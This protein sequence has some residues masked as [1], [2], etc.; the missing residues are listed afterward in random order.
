[1]KIATIILAAGESKRMNGIKQLLPWKDSTL[2]EHAIAQSLQSCTNDVYLVLG[3]NKDKILKAVDT[4]K[5]N[6][7]INDDWSLGMGTSIA[8]VIRFISA[9]H[10]NFDGILIRLIDQPLLDVSYY[11]LLINKYIDSKYIIASSY[12][13]GYGVPAVFD[14]I[15]FDELLVLRSDK[16]AKSIIN[17]HKKE[18]IVV[19]SEGRTIDLDDRQTYLK[20]Y[21]KY[22]K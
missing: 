12:K 3:A 17:E 1:M 10:L 13:S 21:D 19:D 15:Y 22:G 4:R 5:V 8:A 18:L 9:N 2:L 11:N 6:V 14:K 16:G 7:I 20:Y